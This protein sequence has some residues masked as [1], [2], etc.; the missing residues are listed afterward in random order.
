MI[1]G[2]R[3]DTKPLFVLLSSREQVPQ[4]DW[5]RLEYII[6]NYFKQTIT[7]HTAD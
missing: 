3:S 2:G 1:S 4:Y 6:M 7:L 5:K